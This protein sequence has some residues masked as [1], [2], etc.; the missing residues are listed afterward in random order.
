MRSNRKIL[1]GLLLIIGAF[2]FYRLFSWVSGLTRSSRPVTVANTNAGA[3]DPNLRTASI[4]SVPGRVVQARVN[5]PANSIITPDMLQMSTDSL[6]STQGYIT[7][8]E[9]QGAGQ[10]TRVPISAGSN[11]RKDSDLVGHVSET[12][13][14]GL[15]RPGMRAMVVPIANKP[16]LHDLVRIGNY[17]DVLAAFDGQE[18]RSLVSNVRVLGVDV[19]ANDYP[20]VSAAMRGPFKAEAKQNGVRSADGA[21]ATPSPSATPAPGTARPD[22]ALTL[23]V[24]PRQAAALQLA[25]ASNSTLD[26]LV[27][28]SLPG[29]RSMES[30]PVEGA[31]G[32]STSG[33][34][35]TV[36][37]V[38][39]QIAPYAE[40]RK[41]AG[42]AATNSLGKT[43][44][45]ALTK[46][47]SGTPAT[48]LPRGGTRPV[49]FPDGPPFPTSPGSDTVPPANPGTGRELPP[50]DPP[51][52]VPVPTPTQNYSI[53]IYGDGKILRNETVPLPDPST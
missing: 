13:I 20:N 45:N 23:E 44:L 32:S 15:L 10:I 29:N 12:G 14:A 33:N 49:Q 24:T 5:I 25:I 21:A 7:D 51:G 3:D 9:S 19:S 42:T 4:K 50:N 34:V 16:T 48:R 53:P 28:P 2:G 47:L 43:V 35:Q 1:I 52:L 40:A 38:K 17:V 37:V 31:N 30:S 18:S 22:P 41:N 6:P 36:S 26:F 8:I 11:I 46:G 27:R 39:S